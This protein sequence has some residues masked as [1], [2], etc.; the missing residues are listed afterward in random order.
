MQPVIHAAYPLARTQLKR[1][2]RWKPAAISANPSLTRA[3]PLAWPRNTRLQT[4]Q[5]HRLTRVHTR[6]SLAVFALIL[7]MHAESRPHGR[8]SH[9]VGQVGMLALLAEEA[10][11]GA[12]S[13]AESEA[14]APAA[15]LNVGQV[16]T[17]CP[18]RTRRPGRGDAQADGEG[19][20]P[21]PP[22]RARPW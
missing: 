15:L 21:L 6:Y 8:Q 7:G 18:A 4:S 13:C 16:Y 20:I 3:A 1:T 2:R 19:R 9:D 11:Y 17:T 12:L 5:P 14:A 10:M 22:D